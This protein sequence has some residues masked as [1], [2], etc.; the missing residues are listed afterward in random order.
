MKQE[1]KKI[2]FALLFPFIF[3]LSLWLVLLYQTL[4]KVD[5]IEY[6]IHPLKSDGLIGILTAPFIHADI[7]HLL[8]NSFPLLFLSTCIFYFYREIAFKVFILIY[9]VSGFWVWTFARDAYDIGASGLVYGFASFIFFSGLLRRDNKLMALSLLI[10]FIYGGLIWGIIP[11]KDQVSWE[12]HLMGMI[13]GF[14]FGIFYRKAGPQ[15]VPYDWGEEEEDSP[16]ET[17]NVTDE[18]R[19]DAK[20]I[21]VNYE[22]KETK[23]T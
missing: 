2:I 10:T 3:L 22:F 5:L 20:S 17:E 13:A 6:G 8:A 12:S 1:T 4:Y 23:K 21:T 16:E 19:E 7:K 11:L 15:R 14:V 9:L 18:N